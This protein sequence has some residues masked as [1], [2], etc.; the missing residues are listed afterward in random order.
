MLSNFWKHFTHNR[1]S[2]SVH[3]TGILYQGL[4]DYSPSV[5]HDLN[6]IISE[7]LKT[8]DTAAFEWDFFFLKRNLYLIWWETIIMS[9]RFS[10]IMVLRKFHTAVTWVWSIYRKGFKSTL[11]H[12]TSVLDNLEQ[13]DILKVEEY[14]ECLRTLF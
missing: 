14:A 7:S 6:W 11:L 10:L 1:G 12:I 8:C 3:T 2:K 9:N 4:S 5:G 13:M